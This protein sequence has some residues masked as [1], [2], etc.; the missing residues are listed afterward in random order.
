MVV[1][2]NDKTCILSV[3]LINR[4]IDILDDEIES[5][6]KALST[7]MIESYKQSFKI[8]NDSDIRVHIAYDQIKNNYKRALAAKRDIEYALYL[9]NTSEIIRKTSNL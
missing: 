7:N 2:D 3:E 5:Y 1:G 8:N 6:D 9:H 4:I